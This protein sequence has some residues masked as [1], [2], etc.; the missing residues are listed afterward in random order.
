MR[1]CEGGMPPLLYMYKVLLLQRAYERFNNDVEGEWRCM[2]TIH[3]FVDTRLV[4]GVGTVRR[5]PQAG[6]IQIAGESERPEAQ[7]TPETWNTQALG[8]LSSD[9]IAQVRLGAG[10]GRRRRRV[11][12]HPN[13]TGYFFPGAPLSFFTT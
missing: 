8:H 1:E 11:P 12:L 13:V 10:G 5:S 6:E 9:V 4:L 2:H 7:L 3:L